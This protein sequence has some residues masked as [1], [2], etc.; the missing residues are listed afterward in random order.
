M[1]GEH[2]P[3]MAF[4]NVELHVRRVFPIDRQKQPFTTTSDLLQLSTSSTGSVCQPFDFDLPLSPFRE[5]DRKLFAELFPVVC[6]CFVRTIALPFARCLLLI[7]PEGKLFVSWQKIGPVFILT[8]GSYMEQLK[9]HNRQKQ[10]RDYR[11]GFDVLK[12][13][14]QW[15]ILWLELQ[16]GKHIKNLNTFYPI[17]H[18]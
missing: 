16:D 8:L 15:A 18:S 9:S 5:I 17:A 2:T 12:L 3:G 10:L 6:Y 11:F 7:I 13:E 4:P 1:A 14:I